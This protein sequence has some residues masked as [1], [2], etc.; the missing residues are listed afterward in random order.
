M[1]KVTFDT[2]SPLLGKYFRHVKAFRSLADFRLYARAVYS[3]DWAVVSVENMPD[4]ANSQ[5]VGV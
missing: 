1:V 4:G 2:Y 5:N 3:G